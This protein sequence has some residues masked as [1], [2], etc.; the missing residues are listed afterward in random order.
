VCSSDLAPAR[1]WSRDAAWWH[2]QRTRLG[3]QTAYPWAKRLPAGY[4]ADPSRRWPAVIY[5]HGSGGQVPRDYGDPARRIAEAG[6]RDLLGWLAANPRPFTAYALHASA[7]WEPLAV[8]DA[9]DRILAEDRIDPDRVVVMG[10]SMGAIGTWDC[11]TELPGRWA[12][13][14]PIGG[15]AYRAAEMARLGRLPVWSFNGDADPVTT[16]DDARVAVEALRA[17]GGDVRLTVMPGIDH[18]GS[19]DAAFATPG[20]WEWLAGQRRGR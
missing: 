6:S 20:L 11:A 16:L 17:A 2:A 14:V 4:D 19:Q 1:P 7:P 18:G 3:L 5:L 10:F 9:V 12:A 8:A 15:R 13:A